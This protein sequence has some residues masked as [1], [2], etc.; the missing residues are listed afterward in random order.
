MSIT[1]SVWITLLLTTQRFLF[2]FNTGGDVTGHST[3]QSIY[4]FAI[5]KISEIINPV[6]DL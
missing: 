6:I 5:K 3:P 1:S 4:I 2:L